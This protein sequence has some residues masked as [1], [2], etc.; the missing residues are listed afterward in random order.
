MLAPCIALHQIL[1]SL[2]HVLNTCEK[3]GICRNLALLS[4]SGNFWTVLELVILTGVSS[5]EFFCYAVLD[6]LSLVLCP[7]YSLSLECSR[8]NGSSTYNSTDIKASE[9][10]GYLS[11]F[12]AVLLVL[13]KYKIVVVS[14][15]PCIFPFFFSRCLMAAFAQLESSQTPSYDLF[16]KWCKTQHCFLSWLIP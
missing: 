6:F 15:I 14:R 9:E 3:S 8:Y 4:I 13:L 11:W 2:P 7:T 10:L 16:P 12:P 1:E 5:I